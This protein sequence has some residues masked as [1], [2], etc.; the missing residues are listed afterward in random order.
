MLRR[1]LRDSEEGGVCDG[2]GRAVSA[3]GSP[4]TVAG[5]GVD[6]SP[7]AGVTRSEGSRGGGGDVFV[8]C[9]KTE[10]GS[11][12]GCSRGLGVRGLLGT[13]LRIRVLLLRCDG[14]EDGKHAVGAA[15]SVQRGRG[16]RHGERRV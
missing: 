14:A 13:V 16:S 8:R 12:F 6:A 9:T 4:E 7:G 5:E 2:G 1:G 11:E 15:G 10:D 3:M